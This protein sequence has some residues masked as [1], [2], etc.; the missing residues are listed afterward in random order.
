MPTRDDEM[1]SRIGECRHA[2]PTK[3]NCLSTLDECH[4]ICPLKTDRYRE[5]PHGDT[6]IRYQ[7]PSVQQYTFHFNRGIQAVQ[8][9][10]NGGISFACTELQHL[11]QASAV[12]E[13]LAMQSNHN[14]RMTVGENGSLILTKRTIKRRLAKVAYFSL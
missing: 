12:Q 5:I 11:R 7:K 1:L 10:V 13:S 9:N 4:G 8:A 2:L 14:E 6:H 3:E